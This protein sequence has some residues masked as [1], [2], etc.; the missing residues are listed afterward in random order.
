MKTEY[1]WTGKILRVDLTDQRWWVEPTERYTQRFIGGIGVGLKIFWDEVGPNIGALDP[2]NRLIFTPGPLTGTLTPGSGRF[3]LIS[4][5]P[6]SYPNEAVTR[7]GM[8]GYWGPELKYAGYD[9]LVVQGKADNWINLWIHDDTVEFRDARDYV[10]ED[11]FTTQTRLAKELG[12]RMRALCIG[13]AGENL[14]RLAVILSE[15]SFASGRSGFGA[16]MGAKHLKAIAVRGTKPLR[17]F[18]PDRL[19]EVSKRTRELAAMN[20]MREWTT[21]ALSLKDQKH[22]FNSYRRKNTGCFGCPVQCFAFLDVPDAGRSAAHCTN[23]FYHPQATRYYGDSLERDQAVADGYVLANRYGLDTFEF[24]YMVDFLQELHKAG[25]IKPQKEIPL[26]KIGSR[27]FIQKL[28]EIVSLR[29]GIG[30]LLAEGCARTADEI[31]DSWKFAARYF[32]A[33][34]S[35]THG[36][37][38][39]YPEIALMWALDSRDPFIDHHA[40]LRLGITDLTRPKPYQLPQERA[41]AVARKIFGS[42]KAIDHSTFEYKPEAITY[43]QNR[44]AVINLLVICDWIYP[45]FTSQAMKDWIGDTSLESQLLTAVTGYHLSESELNQVGERVWNLAR[46]IMVREGRTRVQDTLHESYFK[47]IDEEKAIPVQDFEEAK[48]KYYQLRGW[49]KETGWPTREKL[50]QLGLSDIADDLR[51]EG[52]LE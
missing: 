37:M 32:P 5:S 38:R 43:A 35:A 34:G 9:A 7:S 30:D 27:E 19:I 10:G 1:G 44:T 20:P 15:T 28:L 39:G 2:E 3:E 24:C 4:K 46:A 41:M 13:P 12:Q 33:H 6:R 45:I 21:R 11:T 16:V 42:E 14:S 29:R 25:N 17:V 31:E 18:D 48:T 23:Y 26:E 50:D 40:Y 52:L 8:G 49:S 22:L 36:K 47:A 51:R